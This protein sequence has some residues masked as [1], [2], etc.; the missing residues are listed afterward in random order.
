MKNYGLF[1]VIQQ[2]D[3]VPDLQYMERKERKRA[4]FDGSFPAGQEQ[5][6]HPSVME[7]LVREL[8][9]SLQFLICGLIQV[10]KEEH[11]VTDYAAAVGIKPKRVM[12]W[13]MHSFSK[14]AWSI[15]LEVPKYL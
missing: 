2:L 12:Y 7:V 5:A 6:W 3:Y 1:E 10:Q 4:K 9:K 14:V 13:Q 8:G 15:N 11:W